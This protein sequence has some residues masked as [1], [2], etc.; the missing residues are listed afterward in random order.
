MVNFSPVDVVLSYRELYQIFDIFTLT[1]LVGG[2]I[3]S[4]KPVYNNV[5][6]YIH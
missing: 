5:Q 4:F 1:Y 3:R 6:I 2:P